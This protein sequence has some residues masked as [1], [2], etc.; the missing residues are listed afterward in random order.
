MSIDLLPDFSSLSNVYLYLTAIVLQIF[1]FIA[2]ITVLSKLLFN[3]VLKILIIRKEK[4]IDLKQSAINLEAKNKTLI[5][6]F[7]WRMTGAREL[8]AEKY[9]IEKLIGRRRSELIASEAKRESLRDIDNV[10]TN[11]E[12]NYNQVMQEVGNQITKVAT[13]ISNKLIDK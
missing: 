2:S 6:E 5:E 9:D 1:I 13:K 3:P 4:I 11:T 12:K 7:E 8:A 10:I